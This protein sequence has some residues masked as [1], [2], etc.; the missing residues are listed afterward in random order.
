MF[1]CHVSKEELFLWKWH[2]S[3]AG[4]RWQELNANKAKWSAAFAWI[5]ERQ[6]QLEPNTKGPTLC[7]APCAIHQPQEQTPSSSSRSLFL[8]YSHS[9]STVAFRPFDSTTQTL[10]LCSITWLQPR[11]IEC[12]SPALWQWKQ[13]FKLLGNRGMHEGL[14]EYPPPPPP[15]PPK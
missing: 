7:L 2:W 1:E 11:Q 9:H 10:F 12:G 3:S 8:F 15:P 5:W 4:E 13:S 14:R 6:K